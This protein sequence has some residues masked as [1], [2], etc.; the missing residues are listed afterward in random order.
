M[1]G[2]CH[3]NGLRVTQLHVQMHVHTSIKKYAVACTHAPIKEQDCSMLTL[4]T[5]ENWR[6]PKHQ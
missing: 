6:E 2:Q 3:M 1:N 5:T 4:V